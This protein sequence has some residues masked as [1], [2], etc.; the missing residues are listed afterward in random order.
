LVV[1]D[2]PL[3]RSALVRGLSADFD[4]VLAANAHEALSML[5]R[6]RSYDVVLCDVMMAGLGGLELYERVKETAAELAP[7]MVFLTGGAWDP[8][9]RA[10]LEALPNERLLKPVSLLELREV[11]HRCVA[12]RASS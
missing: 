10:R 4:V 6:D 1:D 5:G 2:E 9:I 11:I 8:A 3:M 7:R 12:A